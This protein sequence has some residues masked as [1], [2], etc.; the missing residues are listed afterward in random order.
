MLEKILKQYSLP[1][2]LHQYDLN[3]SKQKMIDQVYK[4]IFLDKKKI[5]K[6]PRYIGLKTIYKPHIKEIENTGEILEVIKKFI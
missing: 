4:A 1:T 3:I 2:S 5:N 6:L